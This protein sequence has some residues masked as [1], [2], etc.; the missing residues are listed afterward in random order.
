MKDFEF[1]KTS[2]YGGTMV[3]LQNQYLKDFNI[4]FSMSGDI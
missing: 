2:M 4:P 3:Q 1:E